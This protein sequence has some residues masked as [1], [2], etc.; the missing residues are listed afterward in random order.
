[1]KNL[2]TTTLILGCLTAFAQKG[3][4]GT[5]KGTRETPNGAF[6]ITYTYKV[7]G[8]VLTGTW[9]SEFGE[10]KLQNG[11]VDGKKISYSFTINDRTISY[12]GELVSD[13]EIKLNNEMGE[14][15]LTRVKE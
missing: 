13:D 7:E 12:T 11:E 6:E 3:I 2:L 9:K 8:N 15:K 10:T 4:D 1:M 14:M 5:W